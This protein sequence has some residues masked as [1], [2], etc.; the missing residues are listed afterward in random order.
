MTIEL[1]VQRVTTAQPLPEDRQ[2]EI[3]VA[4]ALRDHA[5]VVLTVRLVEIE[6]MHQLNRR[7][8]GKDAATNVL[9]FPA[10]LPDTIELPLLGDVVLCAPV[11][12][13]EARLQG[14]SPEAHWAHL[15]IH[16]VLH[17]LGHDHQEPGEA[18]VM[19]G[20]EI[21]LLES[22]GFPNPYD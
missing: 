11:V 9:S 13:E 17:L 3:W 1:D 20:L 16:G 15:T 2:F 21:K 18:A 4:T 6:E 22:L 10:E 14:K 19:E 8:R 5:P 12:A 7:F